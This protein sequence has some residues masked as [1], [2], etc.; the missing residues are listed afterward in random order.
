MIEQVIQTIN[1]DISDLDSFD[2][3]YELAVIYDI[4]GKKHPARYTTG[5]Q[6]EYINWDKNALVYH[7]QTGEIQRESVAS[8]SARVDLIKEVVPMRCVGYSKR[9]KGSDSEYT[10]ELAARNLATKIGRKSSPALRRGLGLQGLK[11]EVKAMKIDQMEIWNDETE[12]IDFAV[13][14]FMGLVAVDYEIELIGRQECFPLAT[15]N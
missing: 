14:S 2:N 6:S 12:N 8:P 15:C 9:T 5:G 4:N 10:P 1:S 3:I 7:R 11:V 13:P